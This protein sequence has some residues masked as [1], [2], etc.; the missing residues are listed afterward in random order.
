MTV[1]EALRQ[2]AE[3]LGRQIDAHRR[4]LRRAAG[5]GDATRLSSSKS[6]TEGRPL[7]EGLLPDRLLTR[8]PHRRLLRETLAE[9][10]GVLEETR[11]AFKSKRLEALRKRLVGVLA[12]D[13]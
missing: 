6:E 8:C 7:V 2:S 5:Q 9:V 12:K 1:P 13:A 3:E 11:K 10:I 4:L